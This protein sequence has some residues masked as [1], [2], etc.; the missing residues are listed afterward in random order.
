[1]KYWMLT[2]IC[3]LEIWNGN[4]VEVLCMT[5]IQNILLN[6]Y[7]NIVSIR[8]LP[9][10]ESPNLNSFENLWNELKKFRGRKPN[11][12]KIMHINSSG[13]IYLQMILLIY[14]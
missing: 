12:L 7:W 2:L 1:M 3:P 5:V 13:R 10:S 4:V 8:E 11:N 6:Q 14:T 9:F